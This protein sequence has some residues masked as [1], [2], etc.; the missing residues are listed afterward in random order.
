D[1]LCGPPQDCMKPQ[2]SLHLL[3]YCF[4]GLCVDRCNSNDNCPMKVCIDGT[5]KCNTDKDC[6][7]PFLFCYPV[8]GQ[9]EIVKLVKI[10]VIALIGKFC[11]LEQGMYCTKLDCTYD[12][13]DDYSEFFPNCIYL[14]FSNVSRC[15]G[16]FANSD[17]TLLNN[18]ELAFC[19]NNLCCKNNGCAYKTCFDYPKHSYCGPEGY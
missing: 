1:C 5:Y 15:R 6:P 16:C 14:K 11:N 17:C 12:T 4:K 13:S 19:H 9:Q 10:I 7:A 2:C 3:Q 18:P 8:N